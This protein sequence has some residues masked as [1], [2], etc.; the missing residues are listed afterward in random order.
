V[1]PLASATPPMRSRSPACPLVSTICAATMLAESLSITVASV[2]EMDT[3]APSSVNVALQSRP[4]VTSA[5]VSTR[6]LSI[7]TSSEL[8]TG[9]PSA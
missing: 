5:E 9:V 1:A 4:G 3:G 7:D 2:S 8:G 6:T